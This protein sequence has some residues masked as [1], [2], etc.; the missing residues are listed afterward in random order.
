MPRKAKVPQKKNTTTTWRVLAVIAGLCWAVVLAADIFPYADPSQAHPMDLLPRWSFHLLYVVSI[1]ACLVLVVRP[2]RFGIWSSMCCTWGVVVLVEG[3]G[4]NGILFYL[5]GMGFAYVAGFFRRKPLL[6]FAILSAICLGAMASQLR[7]GVGFASGILLS[8]IFVV[9]LYILTWFLLQESGGLAKLE[10]DIF[11]V[12]SPS[13]QS[14]VE[15]PAPAQPAPAPQLDLSRL[16]EEQRRI[17][18][19]ARQGLVYKEIAAAIG[20]SE[21]HVKRQ[22]QLV[23]RELGAGGQL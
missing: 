21:S 3:G 8:C 19:L 14:E 9:F 16:S 17:L 18:S 11:A 15:I 10:K 6:R 12:F 4:T 20:R 13:S 5:L 1:I 23:R 22:M 7:Y 2:K